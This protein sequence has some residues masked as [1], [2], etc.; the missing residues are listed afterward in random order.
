MILNNIHLEK[1]QNLKVLSILSMKVLS[2]KVLSITKW[3]NKKGLSFQVSGP[4]YWVG[5][6]KKGILLL[7]MVHNVVMYISFCLVKKLVLLTVYLNQNGL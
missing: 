3:P 6:V 4:H 2:I 5:I 1:H 7:I